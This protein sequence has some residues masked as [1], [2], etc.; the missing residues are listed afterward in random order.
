MLLMLFL[1]CPPPQVCNASSFQI[2]PYATVIINGVYWD[3]RTPRLIT[4]PDAKHL[5]TPVHKVISSDISTNVLKGVV[6]SKEGGLFR[7]AS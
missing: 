1:L 2:A 3:A 5:L 7:L 6:I 4:I